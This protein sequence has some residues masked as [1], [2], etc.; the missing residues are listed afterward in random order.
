MDFANPE[1]E[2]T[3][4]EGPLKGHSCPMDQCTAVDLKIMLI[5]KLQKNWY[6]M[7]T[8]HVEKVMEVGDHIIVM[9]VANCMIISSVYL[10]MLPKFILLCSGFL[11]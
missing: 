4:E 8:D 11:T 1:L 3:T 2:L 6:P 5:K 10:M 9:K 7:V